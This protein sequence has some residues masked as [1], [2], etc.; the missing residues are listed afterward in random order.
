VY[1]LLAEFNPK[2]V[3]HIQTLKSQFRKYVDWALSNELPAAKGNYWN[4]IPTDEDWARYSFQHRH[5]KDL[6]ELRELVDVVL[7][8][9]YDK[10][11]IYLLFMGIMGEDCA[12]VVHLKD[13]DVDRLT[14]VIRTA[15][16]EFVAVQPLMDIMKDGGYYHEKKPR[17]EDSVYFVKPFKTWSRGGLTR[18]DYSDVGDIYGAGGQLEFTL[19]K[20]YALYRDIFWG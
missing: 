8:V 6:D 15:R 9:P 2:S 16:R 12:E 10:Y 20:E 19:P 5:V 18:D 17:D 7:S 13:S 1:E 14:G 11:L 3:G 4:L